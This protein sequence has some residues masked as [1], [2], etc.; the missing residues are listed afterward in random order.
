MKQGLRNYEQNKSFKNYEQ[1][2]QGFGE[3]GR[4]PEL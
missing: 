4:V 2:K 3:Q 1:K